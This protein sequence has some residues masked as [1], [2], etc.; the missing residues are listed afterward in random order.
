MS[1]QTTYEIYTFANGRWL[2]DTNFK[3]TQR[4]GAIEEA[5]RI[6]AQPGIE[7]VKVVRETFD[8]NDGLIKE[9]TVFKSAAKGEAKAP[10]GSARG[11]EFDPYSKPA[12]SAK[13]SAGNGGRRANNRSESP[14]RGRGA[15]S[16]P[17]DS[18][19]VISASARLAYKMLI[20]AVVS[21]AFATT[22]TLLYNQTLLS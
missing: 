17:G 3:G 7:Q 14:G 11:A 6:G 19:K 12:K 1:G 15:R 13:P 2:I 20:I 18:A 5:K 21:F 8:V 22:I 4:D 10:N 9:S 16:R